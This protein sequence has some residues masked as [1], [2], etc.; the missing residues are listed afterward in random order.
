MD[1]A[2]AALSA[3]AAGE[4]VTVRMIAATDLKRAADEQAGPSA[5]DEQQRKRHRHA[6][7]HDG[8]HDAEGHA[9]HHNGE[10]RH[11]REEDSRDGRQRH[12]K[13]DDSHNRRHHNSSSSSRA[14]DGIRDDQLGHQGREHSRDK[15]RSKHQES[16]KEHSRGH[17]EMQPSSSR[18]VSREAHNTGAAG[19]TEQRT[20]ATAQQPPGYSVVLEVSKPEGLVGQLVV[21]GMGLHSRCVFGRAPNCD[22]VLEH[23]SISRMHAQ[24]SV[25]ITGQ[26]CIMDLG[27]AHGTKLGDTWLK[28][29]Q[30]RPM[31]P[32]SVLCFGASTRTYKLLNVVKG[33]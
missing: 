14:R 9:D 19:T 16:D 33:S 23:L 29:H 25:D 22:V 10:H 20:A 7:R 31:S 26:A 30:P 8:K 13:H 24:L 28:A 6:E 27:S 1:A 21:E 4:K 11:S 18:E 5:D 12:D 17:N 2:P 15:G 32:G 3:D